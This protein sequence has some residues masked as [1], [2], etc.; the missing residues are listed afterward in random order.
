MKLRAFFQ[1]FTDK[2]IRKMA[3]ISLVIFVFALLA[4]LTMPSIGEDLP[5]WMVFVP[6]CW[7]YIIYILILVAMATGHF[8]RQMFKT[9]E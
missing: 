8:F 2:H 4:K 5:W 9:E 6:L 7:S 3:I 1:K